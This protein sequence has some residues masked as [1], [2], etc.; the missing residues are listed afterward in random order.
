MKTTLKKLVSYILVFALCLSMTSVVF[1]S[2]APQTTVFDVD[3]VSYTLTI[4]TGSNG[5]RT[6]TVSTSEGD[7][8]TSTYNPNTKI[9]TINESGKAP[10][11]ISATH[12]TSS[13]TPTIING[14]APASI[15][16]TY[17]HLSTVTDAFFEKN[18]VWTF[19]NE[20]TGALV[21]KVVY[22]MT[23]T[24]S[25]ITD[26]PTDY[27]AE[28]DTINTNYNLIFGL[29]SVGATIIITIGVL[30]MAFLVGAA[31]AA[32][33]TAITSATGALSTS[34]IGWITE[35][36]LAY[37]KLEELWVTCYSNY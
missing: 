33:I 21:Y 23:S 17:T 7:F 29:G 32:V 13:L 12:L 3:G 20:D 34:I 19:R 15:T 36:V 6:S 11:E 2:T 10:L 9:I 28:L 35:T 14:A 5:N 37:K 4:S 24:A 22:D 1:A 18:D 16:A 25:F 27:F 30:G 26:R 31:L 8:V